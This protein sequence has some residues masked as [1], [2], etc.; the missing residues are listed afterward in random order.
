MTLC[1]NPHDESTR[2]ESPARL[3]VE[4]SLPSSERDQPVVSGDGD[5]QT[6]ETSAKKRLSLALRRRAPCNTK[7]LKE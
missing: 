1:D 5:E 2:D 3:P 6:R 7:G 4:S